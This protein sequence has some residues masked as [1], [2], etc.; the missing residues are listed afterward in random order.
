MPRGQE[1]GWQELRFPV[2][3]L[4]PLDGPEGP[5]VA[6]AGAY[7]D[8]EGAAKFQSV[9]AGFADLLVRVYVNAQVASMDT[10]DE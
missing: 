7:D 8:D 3:D 1:V 10:T 5:G 6:C 9:I 2:G 4:G